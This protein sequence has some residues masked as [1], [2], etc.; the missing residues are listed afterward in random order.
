MRRPL[1][2]RAQAAAACPSSWTVPARFHP[3]TSAA[4]ATHTPSSLFTAPVYPSDPCPTSQFN[5]FDG[6]NW[7][8]QWVRCLWLLARGLP[9]AV[10]GI[11]T[12]N[13]SCLRSTRPVFEVLCFSLL[14]P[15]L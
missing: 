1:P 8:R 12:L 4:K 7:H 5:G 14:A 11:I 15:R 6:I 3:T 13:R 9:C 2:P 10:E